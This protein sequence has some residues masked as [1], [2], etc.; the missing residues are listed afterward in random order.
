MA[1]L[2]S[3]PYTLATYYGNDMGPGN[4]TSGWALGQA[5]CQFRV[6][7]VDS[8]G[9]FYIQRYYW[10]DVTGG[11]STAFEGTYMTSSWG[12]N[13]NV[14]GASG[15]SYL[16][17]GWTDVGWVS[18]GSSVSCSGYVTYTSYDG[19]THKSTVSGTYTVPTFNP[20]GV[21]PTWSSAKSPVKVNETI[22]VTPNYVAS[23]AA[24]DSIEVTD[25]MGKYIYT[26]SAAAF[27]VKPYDILK[28]YGITEYMEGCSHATRLMEC[29]LAARQKHEWYGTWRYTDWTWLEIDVI[30]TMTAYDA[31]GNA[32]TGIVTAYDSEGKAHM[33]LP[34]SYDSTGA[35]V[36]CV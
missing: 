30:G 11:D 31:D 3:L 18:A 22:S 5:R 12:V 34:F 8:N 10:F 6:T 32:H 36:Q 9:A 1:T 20:S 28:E 33:G 4:Y 14:Y 15:N 13:G 35:R 2:T 19:T 21:K 27:N 23:N 16:G 24:F 7:S 26:G 17:T 29:C 25:G